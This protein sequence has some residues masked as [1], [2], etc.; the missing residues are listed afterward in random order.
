M[1]SKFDSNTYIEWMN[2][3]I[4]I[5]NNFNLVIYTDENSNSRI[6]E[7]AKENS[8]IKSLSSH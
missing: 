4:S 7:V 5:V 3:F 6:P 1:K 8:R 2:N